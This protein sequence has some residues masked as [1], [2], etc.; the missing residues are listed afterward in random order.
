MTLPI[1]RWPDRNKGALERL[2]REAEEAP[3]DEDGN[4]LDGDDD[5]VD[6]DDDP[7]V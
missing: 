2:L 4:R 5:P 6:E 3:R 7:D 1:R